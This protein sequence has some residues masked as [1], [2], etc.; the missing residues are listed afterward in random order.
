MLSAPACWATYGE[1]NAE[2]LSDPHAVSYRQWCVD[3]YAVQHPGEPNDQAIQSV[4]AHLLSLYATLELNAPRAASHQ[5][6]NRVIARKGHYVWLTPPL[7][8]TV[9]VRD[10]LA[11]RGH[12]QDAAHQWASCAWHAWLPHH[13]QIK[14]WYSALFA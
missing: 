11:N 9:T 8:F 6:I 10:V 4:A 13:N 1:L 12:L 2:L 3:A 7:S 14:A 5:V